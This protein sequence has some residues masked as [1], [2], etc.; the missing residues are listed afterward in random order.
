ML[1]G[2]LLFLWVFS[3]LPIDQPADAVDW[4]VFYQSTHSFQ[5]DYP[6]QRVFNPPWLLPLLWP[7]TLW[8][9][10]IS[11]GLA[12]LATVT[13]FVLSVPRNSKRAV[14]ISGVLLLVFSY[15]M[16]R[17]LLDGN[18]E[19][20]IV[21]GVLLAI[22]AVA[23]RSPTAFVFSLILLSSKVQETWLVLIFI[24]IAVWR[25][26][27]RPVASKALIGVAA[28]TVPLFIWKGAEWLQALQQFP[29]AQTPIDSS[30]RYVLSQL[31]L[32]EVGAWVIWGLVLLFTVWILARRKYSFDLESAALLVT[33]GL[34]LSSYAAGNSLVTPLALGV[35]PLYQKRPIGG[36]LLT[37]L[38]YLP[39]LFVTQIELRL[40]WENVYWAAVL[41]ITW[42]VLVWD[43]REKPEVH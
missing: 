8:P 27:P 41:L 39:Y 28:W 1:I 32:N 30:L 14:W 37:S 9:L 36:L 40:A 15:P 21:G 31:G 3:L 7:L 11:R 24:A 22:Y 42:A 25:E 20:M 12:A 16:I 2:G 34:L 35:I 26:W 13:V 17:H 18:L 29:Y 19:A 38:F 10:V 4:K 23:K 33:T 6:G 5:I 43:A